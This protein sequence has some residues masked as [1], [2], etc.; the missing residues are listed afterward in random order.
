VVLRHVLDLLVEE[1][2]VR[3]GVT[4]DAVRSLSKRGVAALRAELSPARLAP[5]EEPASTS[6][7]H[8]A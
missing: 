2:A 1:T 4:P 5:G 6:E 8:D 7:H 3:L